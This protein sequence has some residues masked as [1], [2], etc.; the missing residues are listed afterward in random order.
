LKILWVY[1]QKKLNLEQQEFIKPKGYVLWFYCSE[2][3][4]KQAA[5]EGFSGEI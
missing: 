1:H 5:R 2:M 4:K 3:E